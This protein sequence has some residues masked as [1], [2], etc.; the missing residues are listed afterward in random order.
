M[1][2]Q[3]LSP[4]INTNFKQQWI[5]INKRAYINSL[6]MKNIST[7]QATDYLLIDAQGLIY[8]AMAEVFRLSNEQSMPFLDEDIYAH[9]TSDQKNVKTYELFFELLKDVIDTVKVN[10]L[11]YV[12]LDGG[13]NL[14]KISQQRQRRFKNCNEKTMNEYAPV[15]N[16]FDRNS[17]TPGTKFNYEL[18]DALDT[19][20]RILLNDPSYQHL[21]IIM[22]SNSAAGEGEHKLIDYVKN[23]PTI[24]KNTCSFT[25][26]GN[27]G[28]LFMLTMSLTTICSKV[29]LLRPDMRTPT[30]NNYDMTEISNNLGTVVGFKGDYNKK[31]LIKALIL[32]AFFMGNDFLP[33][34]PQY[35]HDFKKVFP[36]I[37]EL[38]LLAT[39]NGTQKNKHLVIN[40]QL[41]Y[42]GYI[43]LVEKL[44]KYEEPDLNNLAVASSSIFE[45]SKN[46]KFNNDL[47]LKTI[48]H[49]LLQSLENGKINM[50]KY[51]QA[52]YTKVFGRND[53]TQN[54][55]FQMCEDMLKT[56]V[57]NYKYYIDT[58]PSWNWMYKYYYTPL[59][60]DYL[61]YLNQYTDFP[62]NVFEF[63][64]G[65][66]IKPF[67]QLL[68]VLPRQS[69]RLLPEDLHDLVIDD[70][71]PLIDIYPVDFKIDYTDKIADHQ[72][73]ALLP[74][75]DVEKVTNIYNNY[76]RNCPDIDIHKRNLFSN[77]TLYENINKITN[78]FK[79]IY[80]NIAF[81]Q[82][83]SR[84]IVN[85]TFKV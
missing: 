59:M 16:K 37:L 19:Y 64:L 28:D 10:K 53:F 78:T 11:V 3:G 43:A 40:D 47:A 46:P 57:W 36:R 5:T 9:L 80:G 75:P 14:L 18:A 33:M 26:V 74:F 42:D 45:M 76:L 51:K 85:E 44:V 24:E 21:K 8:T 7:V 54:D 63:E 25:I 69:Y 77:N 31:D 32:I 30:Y 82:T 23:L 61:E 66:P 68:S 70:R 72:G 71:S 2:V 4:W 84:E 81:N 13:V 65:T 27:D 48:N 60:T 41:N 34:I 1:G 83:Q 52:Y 39:V 55:I 22:S 12:A 15:N 17:V 73:I 79:S 49:E 38:Y 67:I 56:H 58:I 62:K 29:Y 35:P 6:T 50:L 20:L